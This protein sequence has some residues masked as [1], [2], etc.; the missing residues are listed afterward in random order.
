M[1]SIP[2]KQQTSKV[3][4]TG[5][6]HLMRRKKNL[7]KIKNANSILDSYASLI[8]T[9]YKCAISPEPFLSKYVMKLIYEIKF[10]V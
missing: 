5:L 2:R 9:P 6:Q 8:E 10:N 7:E 3:L 1:F 4:P